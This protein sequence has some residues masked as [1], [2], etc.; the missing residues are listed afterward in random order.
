MAGGVVGHLLVEILAEGERGALLQLFIDEA[1]GQQDG[2]PHGGIVYAQQLRILVPE[3]EGAG[4][5]GGDNLEPFLHGFPQYGHIVVGMGGGFLG[6]LVGDEGYAAAFL[7]LQQLYA[8][9]Q[10]IE[11]LHQVFSQ[12]GVVVVHVAAVEIRH[13]LGEGRLLL[14]LTLEPEF[15][16]ASAVFGEGAVPVHG[17]EGVHGR[18]GDAHARDQVG[19]GGHRPYHL[20][21]EIR[22]GQDAVP[23]FDGGA[24]VAETGAL[25]KIG[26]FYPGRAGH[27]AALAIEAVLEGGVEEGGVFE[28]Q[29]FS[30]RAGLLGTRIEWIHFQHGAVHRTDG[31]FGTFLKIVRAFRIFLVLHIIVQGWNLRP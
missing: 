27:L 10:G 12:L 8:H 16:A 5:G 14:T 18:F 25:D 3:G 4:G 21:H 20:A 13:L 11:H 17:Q 15:K 2:V 30:V 23:Q 22:R 24:V 26:H 9:A 7:L 19:D 29:P 28:A 1:G 6:H 31:A